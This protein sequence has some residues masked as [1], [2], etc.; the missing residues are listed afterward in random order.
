MNLPHTVAVSWSKLFQDKD[1]V[2]GDTF[3]VP[4]ERAKSCQSRLNQ[5]GF[6]TKSEPCAEP[7]HVLVR[8]VQ[9][10]TGQPNREIYIKELRTLSTKQ[11]KSVVEACRTNGLI[12]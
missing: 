2:I 6:G 7:G 4:R 10:G 11:L 3:I 5:I 8:V 9:Y 1:I 12:K